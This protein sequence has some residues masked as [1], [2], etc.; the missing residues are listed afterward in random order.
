MGCGACA[1]TGLIDWPRRPGDTEGA[2][3]AVLDG[4]AGLL[5]V[6]YGTAELAHGA[7][8]V[9]VPDR[10]TPNPDPA[11]GALIMLTTQQARGTAA[12]VY[13]S[14]RMPGQFTIAS[15]SER[16]MSLVGWLIIG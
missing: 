8:V 7:A 2:G 5:R 1:A 10:F 14:D 12:G 11:G 9:Q 4:S 15:Y 16:D 6:I 3:L 13:V